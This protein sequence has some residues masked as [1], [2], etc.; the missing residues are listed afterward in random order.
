L[1]PEGARRRERPKKTW[2]RTVEEEALKKGKTWKEV[3]ALAAR[4]TNWKCFTEALCSKGN[5]R[6]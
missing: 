3:E 2:R 6:N 1:K 4:R 5:D